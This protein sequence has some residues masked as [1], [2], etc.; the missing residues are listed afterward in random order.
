M[1]R[2]WL[3]DVAWVTGA[4]PVMVP[5]RRDKVSGAP[6]QAT[7]D[8]VAWFGLEMERGALVQVFMSGVA[9]HNMGNHTQVFGSK[10]TITLS[11]DDEKLWF[12]KAGQGFAEITAHDPNAA[13][14]GL[15]KGIWNVSVVAALQ[16]LCGA[17]AE[18][19]ALR[20]GAT[21]ADGLANQ[22][23]LDAV[24]VSGTERRWVRPEQIDA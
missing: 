9:A 22:R 4:A 11:N 17:I 8:D 16:E 5:N 13:L 2:W 15:N 6:W 3:G 19:R 12:A 7:A 14:P 1:V 21:F 20:R 10:G 18:G 24:R 23:V